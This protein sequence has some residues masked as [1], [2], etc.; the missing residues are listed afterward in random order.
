MIGATSS[1]V[2]AAAAA[3]MDLGDWCE[4]GRPSIS[5]P[6]PTGRPPTAVNS[7]LELAAISPPCVIYDES[8][9]LRDTPRMRESSSRGK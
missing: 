8:V 5:S 4:A 1:S 6:P 7:R 3:Q 9:I 2:P